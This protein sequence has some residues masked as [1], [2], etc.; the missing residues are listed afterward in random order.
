MIISSKLDHLM[1]HD[2]DAEVKERCAQ[3]AQ[4]YPV[5]KKNFLNYFAQKFFFSVIVA[6]TKN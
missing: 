5:N 2:G 3:N 6:L 1:Q 4:D